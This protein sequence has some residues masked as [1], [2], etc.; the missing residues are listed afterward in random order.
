MSNWSKYILYF[1]LVLGLVIGGLAVYAALDHNPQNEF[2]DNPENLVLIFLGNAGATSFPFA[3]TY[4][5]IEAFIFIQ[6]KLSN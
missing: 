2:T 4:G 6:K 1:G 3:L 5:V